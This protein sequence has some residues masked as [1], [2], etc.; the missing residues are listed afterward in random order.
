MSPKPT[1][2][3]GPLTMD[4]TVDEQLD[5]MLREHELKHRESRV[6]SQVQPQQNQQAKQSSQWQSSTASS[7][8]LHSGSSA[9]PERDSLHP[10]AME[11]G[12]AGGLS[13]REKGCKHQ[14]TIENQSASS[15]SCMVPTLAS[16]GPF[17][18][19]V[20]QNM[21]DQVKGESFSR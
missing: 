1:K 9:L 5:M 4:M 3:K 7:S 16:R 6:E 15:A 19:D 17:A 20:E 21:V 14:Q 18:V 11:V 8:L 2:V 12:G 13:H 10:V